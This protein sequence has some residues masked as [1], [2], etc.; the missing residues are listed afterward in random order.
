MPTQAE[1]DEMDAALSA[2]LSPDDYAWVGMA[3]PQKGV[4]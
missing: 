4:R 2:S 3:A 1:I